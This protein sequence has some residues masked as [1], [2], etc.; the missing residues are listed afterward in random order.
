MSVK[1]MM[2]NI[3]SC[4]IRWSIHDFISHNNRNGCFFSHRLRVIRKTRKL[5]TR[6]PWK[7]SS[8]SRSRRTGLAPFELTCPNPYKWFKKKEFYLPVNIRLRKKQIRSRCNCL[9][10]FVFARLFA[11]NNNIVIYFLFSTLEEQLIRG[12][13]EKTSEYRHVM[14]CRR[15]RAQA[16]W[17][18]S[19]TTV[20]STVKPWRRQTPC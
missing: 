2:Y 17:G 8:R 18:T 3:R 11:L 1:V 20:R 5:A 9:T 6:W 10:A 16:G 14:F 19:A 4:A 7:L 13:H 15:E 12:F